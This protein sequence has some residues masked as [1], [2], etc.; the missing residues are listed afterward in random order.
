VRPSCSDVRGND[1]STLVPEPGETW[2]PH[3]LVS[4]CIPT[5]NPGHGLART[6]KCL[7]AQTYPHDLIEVV[8]GDDGSD[9]DFDVPDGLPFP[10]RIARRERTLDFGAGRARNTAA[11]AASGE[12]LFF[13]DGDVIPE[14]QV[15]A[16]Y[17]RWFDRCD[18]VV[19][20]ALCRFVDVDHLSDLELVDL[21][22][23]G[24]MAKVFAGADVDDQDWRE[25]HFERTLDLRIERT[26][27][28]RVAIGAT[29]A[30]SAA[31][32]R[33]VGGFPELG[34]R[35]VEDT[36]FGYRLHNN[37]AVLILDRDA[38][39][40][41]QGRRNLSDPGVRK[42]INDVRA[43]YVES[44]MPVRGFRLPDPPQKAPVPIVP[45]ARIRIENDRPDSPARRSI[46]GLASA[47]L[48]LT[49]EP[50]GTA[51]D[52]ALV[53]VSLPADV[54]WTG[55]TVERIWEVLADHP[56]GV[57][58]AL[59]GGSDGLVVTISRTRAIRRAAQVAPESGDL[60]TEAEAIFGTWWADA[61]QL[62]LIGP[63]TDSPDGV[64]SDGD[65]AET[66]LAG[67]RGQMNEHRGRI[68]SRVYDALVTTLRAL[69]K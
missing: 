65:V 4:I 37:G 50:L 28:F 16:S 23:A 12:I 9:V 53:Q 24:D 29:I 3:A 19:P 15:V 2:T 39:H 10:V 8:I 31:Q 52:Q 45:V 14:R 49:D 40:W 55:Q 66:W 7:A 22:T 59:V 30:V 33:Q 56:V 6:L 57:I 44:V 17:T 25:L 35:G 43:P 67:L 47:N 69:T 13:L 41:H 51:A 64:S 46:T 68:S 5:R 32:F 1:W 62:G 54:E 61:G 27:V 63:R 38:A 21:V 11:D 26:D 34:V 60:T 48:A 58:K 42:R 18:L 20:M 36:A